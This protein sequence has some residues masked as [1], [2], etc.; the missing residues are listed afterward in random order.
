MPLFF[1]QHNHTYDDAPEAQAATEKN[2]LKKGG[3]QKSQTECH[4]CHTA[5]LISSAHKNTPCT[6]FMQEASSN[7][8]FFTA[9]KKDWFL[10]LYVIECDW[11]ISRD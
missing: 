7:M 4:Q 10:S 3:C 2:G 8:R 1:L 11:D 9:A 5:K 6:K